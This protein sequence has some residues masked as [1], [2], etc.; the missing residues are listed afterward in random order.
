VTHSAH[1][2]CSFDQIEFNIA[3]ADP[4]TAADHWARTRQVMREVAFEQDRCVSFMAKWCDEYGQAS[5][6]NVST[7]R[8]AACRPS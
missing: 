2:I 1:A 8:P 3:P 5:H 7:T 6:I 4:V